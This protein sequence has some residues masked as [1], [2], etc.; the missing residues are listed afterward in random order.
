MAIRATAHNVHVYAWNTDTKTYETGDNANITLKVVQDGAAA[1]APDNSTSEVDATNCPGMYELLL[2]VSEMTADSISVHGVSST[3]DVEIIGVT[4]TTVPNVA[5]ALA[6]F[7]TSPAALVDLVWDEV[8][9]GATH[10]VATSSGRRLRQVEAAFVLHAGTAQA[11]SAITIT[12]DAGASAI[13]DFYIHQRV[14]ISG[15]TG[16]EQ[17]RV[18]IAYVGS[19]KVATITHSWDTNPDA[20]SDFEVEPA[21]THAAG[22]NQDLHDGYAQAGAATTITLAASA[23]SINDFYDEE[24]VIIHDGTGG[25]Q[26]RLILSYVGATRVATIDKAWITN[27]DTTSHYIVVGGVSPEEVADAV[28]EETASDHVVSGSMGKEADA[29]LADIELD[30]LMSAAGTGA[31]VIDDS[32][33]AQ[34]VSKETVADFDDFSKDTD[35]LQAIGEKT[36]ISAGGLIVDAGTAQAGTSTTITLAATAPSVS[37]VE[38]IVFIALG[39]GEN[40]VR[41]ISVYDTGTKLA[42]VDTAW[43]IT[44]DATSVYTVIP[45]QTVQIVTGGTGPAGPGADEVTLN[46]LSDADSSPITDADVWIATDVNMTNVIAG[47]SQTNGAGDVTF[48]LDDT[49][50]YFYAIQKD[51]IKDKFGTAFTAIAD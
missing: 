38:N 40:Q 45:A 43:D 24:L 14:V 22:T 1:A 3:A 10:N 19:T 42:T 9:T 26:A 41:T 36:S 44:P 15:G 35:S 11:G 8:L 51:G 27:P 34:L 50:S 32:I 4:I 49:V 37:L 25:G 46:F 47:F 18:I 5:A 21:A 2:S 29:A 17:S 48:M 6:T 13:D 7:W 33:L 28:W 20:T 39:T 12:L 31:N 30:H 16:A 23:S